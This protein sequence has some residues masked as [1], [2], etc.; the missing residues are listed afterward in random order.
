MA[1]R[2]THLAHNGSANAIVAHV[3]DG[4]E[5]VHLFSGRTQCKLHMPPNILH[6][7][8][9]GDGVIDHVAVGS[10]SASRQFTAL[11]GTG[12]GGPLG[13]A[14]LGSHAPLGSCMAVASSGIPPKHKLWR[15]NVCSPH[16]G[17]SR[18]L[19]GSKVEDEER[20]PPEFAPP[21]FLPVPRAD[22]T[23]SHLRGQHG[24]VVLFDN[25]GTLTA[26]NGRGDKLWQRYFPIG[27]EAGAEEAAV[28][29]LTPLSLRPDAVP[30]AVLAIGYDSGVV[31]SEHGTELAGFHVAFPPV[32][33]AIV[34]DFDGDGLSDVIVVTRGGVFG[35][36]QVQHLGGLSFGALLLTLI[37][38]MAI[39][40]Y[41]QQYD[42]GG[43][44]ALAA[45]AGG[46]S[47][48]VPLLGGGM[49]GMAGAARARKMRS[50]EYVD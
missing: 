40:W 48:A 28:P 22:G 32:A 15:T 6:A 36:A 16:L 30:T 10:G 17:L 1:Y 18:A 4:I 31:V 8:I 11:P 42:L 47:G 45:A 24:I 39:V 27:W 2:H 13:V 3:E 49:S 19:D 20:R 23:Y 21:V 9:N 29:T 26:L 43:A 34:A 35:Y 33:P 5:V 46:M 25:D 37:V 38:A 7:D 12:A 50:T 41:S 14:A 44:A